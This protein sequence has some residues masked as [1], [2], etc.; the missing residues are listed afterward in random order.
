MAMRNIQYVQHPL[1]R[2]QLRRFCDTVHKL[3]CMH[4]ALF[5]ELET[6]RHACQP[7]WQNLDSVRLEWGRIT[8]RGCQPLR[9]L[10]IPARGN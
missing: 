9:D 10:A 1:L 4:L 2:L 6:F 7:I 8:R 5:Q 3:L